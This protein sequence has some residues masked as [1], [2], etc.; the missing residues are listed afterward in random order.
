MRSSAGKDM[1]MWNMNSNQA[2]QNNTD[3]HKDMINTMIVDHHLQVVYTGSK[4]GIIKAV[5][6]QD[7]KFNLLSDIIANVTSHLSHHLDRARSP[8][9]S[10]LS[11]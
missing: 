4:D 11:P 7:N 2:G 8:P 6:I 3:I 9:A 5:K 1:R 10:T